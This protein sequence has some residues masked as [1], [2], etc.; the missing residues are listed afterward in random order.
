MFGFKFPALFTYHII[1]FISPTSS[2]KREE[3]KSQADF[4]PHH[5]RLVAVFV[6]KLY[7]YHKSVK[8]HNSF[9]C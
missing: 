2:K 3:I 9:K 5:D 4:L 1:Q 8:D 7:S 6:Y